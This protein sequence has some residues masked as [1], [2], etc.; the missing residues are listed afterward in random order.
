M[1]ERTEE[2]RQITRRQTEGV[3]ASVPDNRRRMNY[4]RRGRT[5]VLPMPVAMVIRGD[6]RRFPDSGTE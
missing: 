3:F 5:T 4:E 1:I 6:M 2:R